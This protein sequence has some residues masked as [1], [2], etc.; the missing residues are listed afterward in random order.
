ME[1]LSK[2]EMLKKDFLD[3]LPEE[4]LSLLKKIS[5]YSSCLTDFLFRHPEELDFFYENIDK[6]LCG[7]E[8]LVKEALSLVDVPENEFPLKLAYFKMKHLGRIVSKDIYKT[9]PPEKLW[10]EYSYLADACFEVAFQ[11]ALNKNIARY[12]KPFRQDGKEAKGSI[13][14]L[15]KLGGLELNYYSDIDVMYVYDDEGKTEKGISNREFFIS[16]FTETTKYLSK[17]TFEGTPWIV[18]LDLRPEGSKGFIAYSLP[19]VEYYYWTHGRT[20]ERHMLIKARHCS[21]SEETSKHFI[22]I[23]TPFVYRKSTGEEVFEEIVEMKKLIEEEAK[24]KKIGQW[25]VKRGEGGIREIEFFV[26]ILLLIHGGKE[27]QLRERN[28]LKAIEKL[29]DKKIIQE[30][31]ANLL[32]EAYLFYRNLEHIIQIDN[33]VQTQTFFIEKA[34]EYA[35]KMGFNSSEEFLKK[36]EFYRKKVRDIFSGLTPSVDVKLTPLQ[37]YILTKQQEEEAIDYLSGLGFKEGKWAIERFK[38]IFFSK[39]YVELAGHWKET[40]FMYI[41]V[42]EKKLKEFPDREDFLL[43]LSKLLIEGKM[44]RIFASAIEQNPKLVDFILSIAKLSDYISDLMAKDE[45]LLDWA[46]GVEEVPVKKEDFDKEV[47]VLEG[48]LPFID[49]LK[50]LKKIVEVLTSLKYLSQI[51][52]RNG[53]ERLIQL[54]EAL[55]N[56]GDYIIENIYNFI[57]GKNFAVFALGKLGSREMNIGSDLDLIFVFVNEESKNRF[58]SKPA[59]IVKLLTS[60]SREGILYQLDLRLRPFG[61]AGELAPTLSFYENYFKKEARPW[62]RLAWTKARF[63]AGDKSVAEKMEKI[64]KEFLFGEYITKDFI[65]S[66]F[67]MRLNLEG[68]VKEIPSEMDIKLGKGG[69][70]DI[71][72]LAQLKIIQTEQRETNVLKIVE[73]HYPHLLENYVF[74]REVE[75]RLRMIK[76]IGISKIYENSPFL[77]RISHS[78]GME[79]SN[80]WDRLKQVKEE[81]RKIFLREIKILRENAIG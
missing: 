23:I 52:H 24:K 71:E 68:L 32:K 69:I 80:L 66:I 70:T 11:K 74:L 18:D 19:A 1:R 73:K 40:L 78:F 77:Y 2:F 34:E 55:S 45:E 30:K 64:I 60:Y 28:I 67:E 41:P 47:A 26:Q 35:F 54:N 5:I 58:I 8:K 53:K 21:G 27:E 65:N 14:A 51:H 33:C 63:I 46:F 49:R 61:K 20:W 31:E 59:E 50:K 13:I 79:P 29:K 75:A 43:N 72:F 6:P 44:L 16:V 15:G 36:L 57:E 62:E 22:D 48:D 10:E 37:R 39:E 76:G 4:K 56:L 12:G 3:S 9:E 42:L 17:K 38:D 7:R 81:N 25:D